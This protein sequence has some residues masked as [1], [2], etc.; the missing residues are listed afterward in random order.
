MSILKNA[1]KGRIERPPFMCLYG[2]EGVGKTTYASSFPNPFFI[3][4]EEGTT[5]FAEASRLFPKTWQEIEEIINDL[6]KPGHGYGSIIV[7]TITQLEPLINKVVCEEN[8]WET[9]ED[10]GYG[11]GFKVAGV[12]WLWL[13]KALRKIRNEQNIP[14]LFCGHAKVKSKDDPSYNESYDR[15]ELLLNNHAAGIIKSNVEFLAFAKNEVSFIKQ[16]GKQKSRAYDTGNKLIYTEYRVAFD[17]KNRFGLPPYFEMP[18]ENGYQELDKM[19]KES[20]GETPESVKRQIAELVKRLDQRPKLA[21]FKAKAKGWVEQYPDDLNKLKGL[22]S[23]LYKV[24]HEH[25]EHQEEE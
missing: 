16:K 11:T 8:D 7:D 5:E 10:P 20:R 24:I 3:D 23:S 18:R 22:V 1:I 25:D 19:I 15:N 13:V 4:T 17:A 12:R 14:I 6:S 2:F 21:D 9:I